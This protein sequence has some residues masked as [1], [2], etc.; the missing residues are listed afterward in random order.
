MEARRASSVSYGHQVCGFVSANQNS[1]HSAS[2]SS[3]GCDH[4]E[5]FATFPPGA[6][7]ISINFENELYVQV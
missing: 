6:V 7:N 3:G 5:A 2:S 4:T 1:L